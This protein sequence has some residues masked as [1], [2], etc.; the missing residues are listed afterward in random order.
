MFKV[1]KNDT[2]TKRFRVYTANLESIS[3]LFLVFL[4]LTL[5]KCFLLI[6]YFD[7]VYSMR[8]NLVT[9]LIM[10]ARQQLKIPVP[11]NWITLLTIFYQR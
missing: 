4:L 2:R 1:D 9:L 6:V 5:N 7:V 11:K 10:V 8:N 3:S